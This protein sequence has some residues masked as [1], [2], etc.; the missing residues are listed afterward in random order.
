MIESRR[1]LFELARWRAGA[2]NEDRAA[3]HVRAGQVVAIARRNRRCFDRAV[4][5]HCTAWARWLQAEE[6]LVKYGVVIESPNGYPMPSPY[7]A[8]ANK[9]ID[10]L[11]HLLT[12]FAMS[13]SARTRVTPAPRPPLSDERDG[14]EP[15]NDDGFDPRQ[16]LRA[17]HS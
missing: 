12:E 11:T 1:L 13:P 17:V 16:V 15:Y 7:L 10:Q 9:S 8:I 2:I 3:E 14:I 6:N 5:W 4:S